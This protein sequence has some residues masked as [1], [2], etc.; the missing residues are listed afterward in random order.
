MKCVQQQTRRFIAAARRGA[1][2]CSK[3]WAETA[4]YSFPPVPTVAAA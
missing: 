3:P 4:R 2:F 1:T